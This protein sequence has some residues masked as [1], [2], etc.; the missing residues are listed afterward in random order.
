MKYYRIFT[1]NEVNGIVPPGMDGVHVKGKEEFFDNEKCG[2]NKFYDKM[3]EFDYLV[4]LN[5]GGDAYED[6]PSKMICDLHSWHGESPWGAWLKPMSE[7]FKLLLE[8][9]NLGDHRFYTA[10][11]LF[12]DKYYNYYVLQI[13]R[14]LF[15]E[16][17]DFE[18]SVFNN[19]DSSRKL[20]NE[21]LEFKK[22]SSLDEIENYSEKNWNWD[23]NY[24]RLIMKPQFKK[25]D[26]TTA[27]PFGDLASEHLKIAI[28][29]A[30]L[31]GIE[32]EELP[33]PIEFSDEVDN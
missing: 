8:K 12:Q 25:I 15:E 30:G 28:E 18:N 23:F 14:G 5:F 6:E 21:K 13:L 1:A 33:I 10:K 22:V 20:E 17:I 27:W 29:D 4:P 11:V 26:F 3:Y 32:F 7:K 24:E 9:F 19:L 2:P 16:H 31:T